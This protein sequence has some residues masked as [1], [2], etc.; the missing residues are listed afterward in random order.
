MDQ[1][2]AVGATCVCSI[3]HDPFK[4]I[5]IFQTEEQAVSFVSSKLAEGCSH[6]TLDLESKTGGWHYDSF[7]QEFAEKYLLSELESS[8]HLLDVVMVPI[9]LGENILEQINEK[10][11]ECSCCRFEEILN[12]IGEHD[13]DYV[14]DDEDDDSQDEGDQLDD[15]ESEEDDE[16]DEEV[17]DLDEDVDEMNPESAQG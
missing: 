10:Y 16:L 3:E 13:E 2:I 6:E 7:Q 14:D 9:R 5:G 17:D 8:V 4:V 11:G 12:K 15:L 1:V